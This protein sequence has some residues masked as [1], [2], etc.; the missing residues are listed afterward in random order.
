M[1]YRAVYCVC[2]GLCTVCVRGCVLCVYGAVYCVCTGNIILVIIILD[3]KDD[4]LQGDYRAVYCV[5]TGL[6]HATPCM[7][8][9]DAQTP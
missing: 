4:A 8:H 7:R 3:H 2:T 6:Q 1:R 5:C 9:T